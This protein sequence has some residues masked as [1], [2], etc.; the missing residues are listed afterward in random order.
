MCAGTFRNSNS[1]SAFCSIRKPTM[2]SG[3]DSMA[4][5]R[6]DS[7][8]EVGFLAPNNCAQTG[9]RPSRGPHSRKNMGQSMLLPTPTAARSRALT[10]PAII[11]SVVLIIICE[12]CDTSI[13]K[14]SL[15]NKLSSLLTRGFMT[16]R[17][18][19]CKLYFCRTAYACFA[20]IWCIF[21]ELLTVILGVSFDGGWRGVLASLRSAYMFHLT[22]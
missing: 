11:T 10:R 3:R 17:P 13:G 22:I 14:L 18:G 4:H 7:P 20:Y 6:T 5:W 9:L 16:I 12:D 2:A 8:M 21:G 1:G 19:N 15:A